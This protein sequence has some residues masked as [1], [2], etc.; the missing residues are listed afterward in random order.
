MTPSSQCRGMA[1]GRRYEGAADLNTVCSAQPGCWHWCLG[2]CLRVAVLGVH[3]AWAFVCVSLSWDCIMLVLPPGVPTSHACQHVPCPCHTWALQLLEGQEVELQA[4]LAV[5]AAVEHAEVHAMA[6]ARLPRSALGHTDAF[7][8][9]CAVSA[10]A[11]TPLPWLVLGQTCLA[12]C[13]SRKL[14][15]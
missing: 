1:P 15:P 12:A 7:G 11:R 10:R 8:N 14:K 13:L 9:P 5:H 4:Q 6:E 3:H 2:P